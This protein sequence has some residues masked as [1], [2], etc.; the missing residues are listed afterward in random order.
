MNRTTKLT[1]AFITLSLLTGCGSGSRSNGTGSTAAPATSNTG[2]GTGTAPTTTGT[3]PV[4]STT[5][6]ATTTTTFAWDTAYTAAPA[7]LND[8]LFA[9]HQLPSGEILTGSVL[10]G[11]QRVDTNNAGM[12]V[13]EGSFGGVSSFAETTAG[14]IFLGTSQPF[15][16]GGNLGQVHVRD[17]TGAWTLSLDHP[18]GGVTIAALGAD[19]Y[20]FA[21]EFN[22]GPDATVSLLTGAA[23]AVWQ[24]DVATLTNCQI[25]KATPWRNEIWAGGCDNSSVAGVVRLFRGTG[26]TFTEVTG[27]PD[28]RNGNNQLEF[29]TDL[30]QINGEL[31]LAT[32]I[33]DTLTGNVLGGALHKTNDGAAWTTIKT[34]SFDCPLTVALHEG[35]VFAGLV[36]GGLE[37]QNIVNQLMEADT[38]IPASTGVMSLLSEATDTLLAGIRGNT[39]AELFRRTTT[40]TTTGGTTTTPPATGGLTYTTDIKPIMQAR[41]ASCHANNVNNMAAFTSFPLTMSN[42]TADHAELVTRINQQTP[43]AS[44]LLTKGSGQVSHA[45]GASIAQGSAEYNTLVQWIQAGAPR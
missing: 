18:L 8:S 23:N 14:Q 9:L 2:T 15:F 19:V 12:D 35:T 28:T 34:Y 45:G 30:K 42:D 22:A 1:A 5:T 3:A 43:D 25:N 16:M 21:S 40:T 27:V 29:C 20:A 41:C 37:K 36:S 13:S 6:P 31:Y 26:A 24:Q 17:A 33:I 32:A 10:G 39:G 4:P 7:V 44:L 11:V 38:T